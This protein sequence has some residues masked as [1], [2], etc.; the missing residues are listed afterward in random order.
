M[1]PESFTLFH[2]VEPRLGEGVGHLC[3]GRQSDGACLSMRGRSLSLSL[4]TCWCWELDRGPSELIRRSLII[5]RGKASVWRSRTRYEHRVTTQF[6]HPPPSL[7][8]LSPSLSPPSPMPVRHSTS[9][10]TRADQLGLLSSPQTMFHHSTI[11]TRT[12]PPSLLTPQHHHHSHH[13]TITTRGTTP[14]PLT[15]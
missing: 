15:P 6:F 10:W 2:L 5:F 8:L 4:Q 1:C 14:S 13:T 7:S 9:S 11:T 3:A 12:T